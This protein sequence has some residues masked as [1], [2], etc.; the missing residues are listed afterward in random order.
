VSS[1]VVRLRDDVRVV[2]APDGSP[3]TLRGVMT[4]VPGR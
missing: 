4:V 3:G 1:R 2:P